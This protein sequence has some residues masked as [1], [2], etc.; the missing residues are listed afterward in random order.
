[1]EENKAVVRQDAPMTLTKML[2]QNTVKER[3]S[4]ILKEKSPAFISSIISATK[5]NPKLAECNPE[6]IISSAVIAATLDLPIQQNLGFAWIIPYKGQAQ[7]QMGYK[8]YIQLAMR[9]G[10]YKTLNVSEVC[11]GELIVENKF[12]GEFVFDSKKATSKTVIGYMAYFKLINGFEKTL[13]MTAMQMEAHAKKYSQTYKRGFG[14]WEEDFDPMAQKT[15]IKLLLSKYGILSTEMQTAVTTDQAVVTDD[16]GTI[17]VEYVD[18]ATPDAAQQQ[19]Q[20]AETTE[21]A[22]E[23][24]VVPQPQQEAEKVYIVDQHYA[25]AGPHVLPI[26]KDSPRQPI[27]TGTGREC[28]DFITDNKP[29][30]EATVTTTTVEEKEAAATTVVFTGAP[31]REEWEVFGEDALKDMVPKG[32]SSVVAE[33]AIPIPPE[34]SN[35][36]KKLRNLILKH[37]EQEHYKWLEANYPA[38]TE[39]QPASTGTVGKDRAFP[40]TET[41]SDLINSIKAFPEAMDGE[42]REFQAYQEMCDMMDDAGYGKDAIA[43]GIKAAGVDYVDK[44]HLTMSGSLGAIIS[45]IEASKP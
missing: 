24:I 17:D 43:V 16:G 23:K 8:G 40:A 45:V 6:S 12:T 33:R 10:Q 22:A 27:F 21:Q 37:Q 14:K 38:E 15:V 39:E 18:N 9:T 3:F 4:A 11:E 19:E 31:W 26:D 13:Y 1:M 7:F 41:D 5:S 32:I 28:E 30:S 29:K 44:E 35:T 25:L 36:N 20:L 2:A 34:G 42:K